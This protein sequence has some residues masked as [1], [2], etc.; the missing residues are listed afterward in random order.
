[1]LPFSAD[2]RLFSKKN[3]IYFLP[4]KTKKKNRPQKLHIISPKLFFF[5][6]LPDCQNQPKID[7]SY[8]KYVPRLIH[9]G[10][11]DG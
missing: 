9:R 1:M 6:V 10:G 2:A 11:K 7:F 8:H 4:I 5:T 3:Q